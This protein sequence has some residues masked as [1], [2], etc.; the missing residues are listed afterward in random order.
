MRQIIEKKCR[1]CSRLNKPECIGSKW[2]QYLLLKKL[3]K[4][5]K[6]ICVP[7][8]TNCN[9]RIKGVLTFIEIYSENSGTGHFI[10]EED[11][12]LTL[13]PQKHCLELINL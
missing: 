8:Y 6:L 5:D 4:G 9:E 13:N 7:E 11:G 2:E 10:N 12:I 3:K 1:N